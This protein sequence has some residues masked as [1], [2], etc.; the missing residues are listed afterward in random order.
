MAQDSAEV[1]QRRNAR[2]VERHLKRFADAKMQENLALYYQAV[3]SNN[4]QLESK[5]RARYFDF[6]A[7]EAVQ[8]Y[9]DYY[10]DDTTQDLSILDN[11]SGQTLQSFIVAFENHTQSRVEQ[12]GYKSFPKRQWNPAYGLWKN[13]LLDLQDFSTEIAPRA[14]VLANQAQ[15]LQLGPSPTQTISAGQEKAKIEGKK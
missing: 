4:A 8:Q 5:T 11:I 7:K 3:H 2:M 15:N 14:R 6:V 1:Y 13:F 12:S 9:K 10:E